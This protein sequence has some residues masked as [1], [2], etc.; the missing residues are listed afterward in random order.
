MRPKRKGPSMSPA[1]C[2]SPV[3]ER[4]CV[5]SADLRSLTDGYGNFDTGSD[6]ECT[7]ASRLFRKIPKL[8]RSETLADR[9]TVELRPVKGQAVG[10]G[11]PTDRS[12]K[13]EDGQAERPPA[14]SDG[15]VSRVMSARPPEPQ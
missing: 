6:V 5:R 9:P 10:V 2:I 4:V 12:G 15:L 3:T 14:G 8:T 1:P 7:P 13:H 11:S